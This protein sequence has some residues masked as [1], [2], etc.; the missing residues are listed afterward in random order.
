MT[1]LQRVPEAGKRSV[2]SAGPGRGIGGGSF[3]KASLRFRAAASQS[4]REDVFAEKRRIILDF[5]RKRDIL[6]G[7]FNPERSHSWENTKS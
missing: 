7:I 3:G 6:A 5:G 1:V 2:F 4:F